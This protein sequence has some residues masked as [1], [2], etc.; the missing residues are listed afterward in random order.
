MQQFF[1]PKISP[2]W[3]WNIYLDNGQCRWATLR[4]FPVKELRKLSD[5]CG[6]I[7]FPCTLH[8]VMHQYFQ[9]HVL[10]CF[11]FV[12]T[13]VCKA[14]LIISPSRSVWWEVPVIHPWAEHDIQ[15]PAMIITCSAWEGDSFTSFII[16]LYNAGTYCA[17]IYTGILNHIVRSRLFPDREH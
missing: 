16:L 2:L 4:V 12:K 17:E 6:R 7:P 11:C 13:L 5:S 3:V 14:N 10:C 15:P 9:Y 1:L 8:A